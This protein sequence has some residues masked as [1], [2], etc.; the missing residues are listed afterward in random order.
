MDQASAAAVEADF[1]EAD[2]AAAAEAVSE[3]CACIWPCFANFA[4]SFASFAV[5]LLTA[6]IAKN[7][8]KAAKKS[9]SRNYF[10]WNRCF[11]MLGQNSANAL[12]PILPAMPRAA[13]RKASPTPEWLS[14][15]Q[16]FDRK[17]PPT[18]PTWRA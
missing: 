16:A 17:L 5:K 1:L 12:L 15:R 14:A 2:L 7:S 8:A 3:S 10:L 9:W 4:G 13:R 11:R 6:K 18:L